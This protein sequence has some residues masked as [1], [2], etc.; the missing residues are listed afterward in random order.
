MYLLA[1][2]LCSCLYALLYFLGELC[3]NELELVFL[4]IV[5]GHLEVVYNLHSRLLNV[6]PIA[7]QNRLQV[8]EHLICGI[9]DLDKFLSFLISYLAY[10]FDSLVILFHELIVS[11]HE[12]VFL[13]N[14]ASE[15]LSTRICYLICKDLQCDNATLFCEHGFKSL[16]KLREVTLF[17]G[18]LIPCFLGIKSLLCINADNSRSSYLSF[19][20][21]KLT[22][23]LAHD[24]FSLFHNVFS[25][26]SSYSFDYLVLVCL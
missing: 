12:C 16:F 25:D 1:D 19:I 5:R 2:Y 13:H 22:G 8:I 7:V 14:N 11:H 6:C 26:T 21:R 23:I 18:F 20:D 3:G 10:L 9:V 4:E 17:K 24:L 15:Y